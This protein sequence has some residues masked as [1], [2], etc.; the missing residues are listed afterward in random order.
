MAP[1]VTTSFAYMPRKGSVE[2][3]D[4]RRSRVAVL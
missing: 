3:L 1:R 4:T 2:S